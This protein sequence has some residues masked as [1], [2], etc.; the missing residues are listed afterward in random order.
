MLIATAGVLSPDPVADFA[1]RLAAEEG[2]V[3]VITVIEVPRSFLDTIRSEHWH[4][5]SDGTPAWSDEEDAVIE[6]Y[7]SERG[8]R[9]TE[10]ILATL[11]SR[12]IEPSV[13]YLEGEDP[14]ATIVGE[15]D[16]MDADVVV[17]GATRQLFDEWESVS[18]RVMRELNR[19]VLVV[20]PARP[21]STEQ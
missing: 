3:A 1:A 7:V 12:G 17:L 13:R 9:I 21:E 18:A 20:P 19:P 2:E 5:L 11:R 8:Q 4:P 6:R 14:A 15:A 16:A 10:P